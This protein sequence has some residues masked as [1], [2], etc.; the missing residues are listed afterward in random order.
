MKILKIFFSVILTLCIALTFASCGEE[1]LS[2]YVKKLGEYKGLEIEKI[3]V[4][5][6]DEDLDNAINE[7]LANN[8]KKEEVTDRGVGEK[9]I[10]T[11]DFAGF[12]DGEQFEGGTATDYE[13]DIANASMIDGFVEGIMGVKAG[14]S[15]SLDLKFPDSY[16]NADV[17]GKPVRFDITVKKIQISVTPE[18]DDEFCKTLGY[19]SKEEYE[20]ELKK[21]LF[22]QKTA[23]AE[24][25]RQNSV[26]AQIIETTEIKEYPKDL[27]DDYVNASKAELENYCQMFSMSAEEFL[28]MYSGVTLEEY[29][30]LILLDAQ[31]Y[32]A[33]KIVIA[34]IAKKEGLEITKEEYTKGVSN[35]AVEYE[36]TVSEFEEY[37]G[38]ETIKDSLLWVKIINFVFEN[39]V[40]K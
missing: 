40:E 9:D 13:L 11:I 39:A 18:Y 5:V 7:Q 3:N 29:N 27:I 2:K 12:I 19:D 36:T 34:A 22:S 32:V 38:K 37:Y 15:V 6:T 31:D 21:E 17:A 26:W 28:E 23:S 25:E 4:E 20:E 10:A 33:E 30:E 8:A 35:Y 1:D 14:E 16:H 24:N